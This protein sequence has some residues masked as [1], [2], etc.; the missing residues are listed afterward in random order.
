[1]A[2]AILVFAKAPLPG[3]V[4]TRLQPAWTPA[5]A[6]ELHRA[7]VDDLLDMLAT[8]RPGV[9]VELHTDIA[10]DAWSRPGVSRHL[11]AG[12]DLGARMLHAL[13]HSIAS[14]AIPTMILG[15]DAPNLPASHVQELL[16]IEAD[17][18]LGPSEDGG[19]YAICCR[20]THPAMIEG[21]EWSSSR[22]LDDTVRA[23][24]KAGLSVALGSTWFDI[25]SADDLARLITVPRHTAAVLAQ[26]GTR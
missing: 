8:L 9:A 19:Y 7:F 24:R 17:V 2:A 4:K 20:R 11:Q 1:V 15:G 13:E 6:A 23:A 26:W 10:T 5:Q 22:A 16:A 21:V 18:A 25:D 12:G 14:G 3:R